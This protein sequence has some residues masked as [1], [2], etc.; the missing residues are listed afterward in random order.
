[1]PRLKTGDFPGQVLPFVAEPGEELTHDDNA[2]LNHPLPSQQH[3]L[4][5][6]G[7]ALELPPREPTP[8]SRSLT[9]NASVRA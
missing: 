3:L 2:R 1:M 8:I 9:E 4:P 6:L 7:R 5:R